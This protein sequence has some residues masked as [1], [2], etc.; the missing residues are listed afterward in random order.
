MKSFA[1]IRM[2]VQ[3][4]TVEMRQSVNVRREVRRNPVDDDADA[5]FVTTVDEAR[6]GFRR[7]ESRRG[8]ELAQ[9]LVTP[10]TAERMLRNRQQLDMG[11]AHT[12]DI[13][14]EALANLVPVQFLV[15]LAT[16]PGA[17]V[18]FVDRQR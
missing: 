2:L 1:R 13:R 11:E 8:S 7:A 15:V 6:K 14:N 3:R 5:R 18:Q 17:G 16:Q 10:R 12:R 4:R 9:R